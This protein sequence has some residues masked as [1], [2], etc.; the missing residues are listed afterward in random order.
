MAI[1]SVD[2]YVEDDQ[3]KFDWLTNSRRSE[4]IMRWRSTSG[5]GYA[6]ANRT[7]R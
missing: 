5:A 2:G 4:D 7:R 3:G 1:A 6:G